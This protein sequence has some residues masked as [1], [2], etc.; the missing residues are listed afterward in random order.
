MKSTFQS[1]LSLTFLTVIGVII[2]L[3]MMFTVYQK[4]VRE[5]VGICGGV[6]MSDDSREPQI[7]D[8]VDNPKLDWGGKLFKVNCKACH[9]RDRPATGPALRGVTQR[10]VSTWIRTF[11]RN[12]QAMIDSGDTTVIKMF[13]EYGSVMTAFPSITDNEIDCILEYVETDGYHF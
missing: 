8:Y 4:P 5:E 1:I 13:E 9:K 3:I 11:I 6:I 2:V 10:R 7:I 12:P